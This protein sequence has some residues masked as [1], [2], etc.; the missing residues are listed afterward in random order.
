MGE[1]LN[2]FPDRKNVTFEET[3]GG[4]DRSHVSHGAAFNTKG[5]SRRLHHV[6]GYRETGTV[7]MCGLE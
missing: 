2:N 4:L 7:S 6:I 5:H 1:I 3:D